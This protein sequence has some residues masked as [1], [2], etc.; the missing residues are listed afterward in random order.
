MGAKAKGIFSSRKKDE[1][2]GKIKAKSPMLEIDKEIR[3]TVRNLKSRRVTTEAVGNCGFLR[4]GLYDSPLFFQHGPLVY[5]VD[6]S[7]ARHKSGI[8]RF[9][10]IK[11]E[12]WLEYADYE[13]LY[14]AYTDYEAGEDE[15]PILSVFDPTHE[16]R[17]GHWID[18]AMEILESLQTALRA[19]I[20]KSVLDHNDRLLDAAAETREYLESRKG[21]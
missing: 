2:R 6:F 3:A 1:N 9:L 5:I 11:G 8:G 10:V 16:T 18:L 19:D 13:S 21:D 12:R 14:N 20:R 15:V 17:H 7:N 4:S